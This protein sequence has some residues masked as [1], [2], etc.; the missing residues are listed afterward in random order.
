MA[1]RSTY[2]NLASNG[3]WYK[4]H[5]AFD[6]HNRLAVE[7]VDGVYWFEG[8][9]L[10]EVDMEEGVEL[11]GGCWTGNHVWGQTEMQ[12]NLPKLV[13]SERWTEEEGKE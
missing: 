4:Q 11:E 3:K 6:A 9:G 7:F 2:Y 8:G 10:E 12:P 5:V 1:S 13:K